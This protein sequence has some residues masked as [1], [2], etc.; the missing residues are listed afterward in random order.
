MKFQPSS[1]SA[2]RLAG[3]VSLSLTAL[4]GAQDAAKEAPAKEAPAKEAPAKEEP[5]KEEGPK[6]SPEEI[7]TNASMALGLRAG[8]DFS[9]QFSH[10]GV[11]ISDLE[12]E[13]FIK[14]FKVAFEEKDLPVEEDVLQAA[15]Q[16]FGQLIQDREVALAK[17][18]KEAG[19]K[20]LAENGKRKGVTTTASGLQY[21][22]LEKGGD[23]KYV[24][25]K[26]PEAPQKLFKV[27]YKGTLIDGTEFDASPEGEAVPMTL[28]VV[29]GFREALTTM[30]IGAKWKL[31]LSPDLAYGERRASA[32]LGP[33]STLIFELT[34]EAIEDA[35]KPQG[36]PFQLPGQ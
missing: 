6:L 24:E 10:F 17:T 27:H 22:I 11:K 30:P 18:N 15:M 26:G 5:A 34:L 9:R 2:C 21:E 20:F 4:L 33:N 23:K 16:A 25:P 3:V 35:P 32:K 8:G 36:L 31:Y 1:T 29:P 19:E 7:K 28:Q 13:S 14:G 12:M